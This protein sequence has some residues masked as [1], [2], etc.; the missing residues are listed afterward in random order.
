MNKRIALA[1][2]VVLGVG[3]G[4]YALTRGGDDAETASRA[5]TVVVRRGSLV[6]TAA[7]SGKIEP[8]VQV[9]VKSRA[10]GE[11]IEVLVTEGQSVAQGDVLVR[12][13]PRDTARALA[14]ARATM[15]RFGAEVGQARANLSVSEVEAEDA[16]TSRGV[17]AEGT[18]LGLVSSEGD[19]A[20]ARAEAIATA[21]VRLRRAQVSAS[22]AQIATARLAMD[23]A[24][25]RMAETEIRAPFAGTILSVGVEVGS[26]VSSAVTNVSG[27][28]AIATLADLTDLRVIGQIDEAQIGR[29]SVDQKVDIRVDA[30]PDRVFE[31]R[32]IRVSPLGKTVSNVVTFDVE[33][34][35]TDREAR[36]LRSGM[37]ADLEIET[38]RL[39]SV[40][41]VP[42][43]AIQTT[44]RQRFVR[45]ASGERRR[46][47]T[48]ANDGTNL[49]IVS[50]LREGDRIRIGGE[51]RERP[52]ASGGL[53]SP[54]RG[55]GRSGGGG[56]GPR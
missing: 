1:L 9:E 5:R 6:E 26:I 38:N 44:G 18:A 43:A 35:V 32:V 47:R 36:L 28:I 17:S 42:L 3:A 40:L 14:E 52:A 37:S 31:G 53:F 48:G 24:A 2:A 34:V 12:L 7:A 56:G 55:G 11:V 4:A 22:A 25:L 49:V 29:V 50:G 27:G 19:R 20:A 13:D 39:A 16:R 15:R 45:L 21:N 46:V 8:H 54:P 51:R 10:S 30:Y 41:L 33:I 23:E